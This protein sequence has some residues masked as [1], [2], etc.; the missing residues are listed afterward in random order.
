MS[1][2]CNVNIEH[3]DEQFICA[4]SK[5]TIIG[6]SSNKDLS[7]WSVKYSYSVKQFLQDMKLLD[8]NA[9]N[10]FTTLTSKQLTLVKLHNNANQLD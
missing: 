8:M 4:H 10:N 9:D 7:M 6:L 2:I 3:I 5:D 1:N